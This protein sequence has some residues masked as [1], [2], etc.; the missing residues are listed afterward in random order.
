MRVDLYGMVWP[1]ILDIDQQHAKASS[2]QDGR[3]QRPGYAPAISNCFGP[4]DFR[5][6]T[7]LTLYGRQFLV[8]DCDAFTRTWLQVRQ[9]FPYLRS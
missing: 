1:H 5:I 6:G 4:Q 2:V 7:T 3:P 9:H 8:Y